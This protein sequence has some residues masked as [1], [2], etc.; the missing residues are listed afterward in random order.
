MVLKI[1]NLFKKLMDM[2]RKAILAMEQSE[3]KG[4]TSLLFW[5]LLFTVLKYGFP[6]QVC[7][8]GSF[9]LRAQ[10]FASRNI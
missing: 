2:I 1:E 5:L 9:L 8:C 7:Q 4:L 6:I 10:D 3:G